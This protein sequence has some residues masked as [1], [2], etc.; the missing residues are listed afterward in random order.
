MAQASSLDEVID[1]HDR[2]LGT[3]MPHSCQST[4]CDLVSYEIYI[5]TDDIQDRALLSVHHEA[6]NIEV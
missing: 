4:L 2:Y 1:A 5:I 6:L 3:R